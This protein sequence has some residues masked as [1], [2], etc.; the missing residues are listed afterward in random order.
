MTVPIYRRIAQASLDCAI[1]DPLDRSVMHMSTLIDSEQFLHEAPW[2]GMT[3]GDIQIFKNESCGPNGIPST[4]TV[5]G[6]TENLPP[7]WKWWGGVPRGKIRSY[8]FLDAHD[9]VPMT[10]PDDPIPFEIHG[11]REEKSHKSKPASG[12]RA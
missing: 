5:D 12:A 6:K 2:D 3:I 10:L 1:N 4:H 7:V 9:M 11:E 8:R